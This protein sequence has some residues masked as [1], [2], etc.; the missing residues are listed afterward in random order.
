[1]ASGGLVRLWNE[2]AMQ[3]MVIVSFLLQILLLALGGTRRHSSS[4]VVRLTL[5]LC[6]LMADSTAIYSLGHLSVAAGSGKHQLVAFW[7]P[8]LLLHLG[9][10]DN[11]TAFSLEDN[12]LWL[13]HLQ[14][15]VLQVLGAA[16]VVYKYMVGGG[17]WLLL[18]S[19]SIFV[20]G[21]VK[22]GERIWALRC[23][24]ISNIRIRPNNGQSDP[25]AGRDDAGPL[26]LQNMSDQDILVQAHS[27]FDVCVGIFNNAPQARQHGPTN[28]NAYRQPQVIQYKFAEMVLSLLYDILYTKASVLLTW[29]G[30]CIH[31]IPPL[32][33][34]TALLLFQINIMAPRE[35]AYDR[36]DVIISYVLLVGA[37]VLDIISLCRIVLSCWTFFFLNS[38][39]G[40]GWWWLLQVVSSLRQLVQCETSKRLWKGS[41]GQHD[42]FHLCAHHREGIRGRLAMKMGFQDSWNKMHFSETFLPTGFL[43]VEDLKE[44]VL[45]WLDWY[46]QRHLDYNYRDSYILQTLKNCTE[47]TDPDM[48]QIEM[49]ER[50]LV[51]HIA[52]T[53]YIWKTK[54]EDEDKLVQKMTEAANV[55]SNY[56]M[57]LLVVKPDMLPGFTTHNPYK[58][59][60]NFMDNLWSTN[61][62]MV[63][64]S[65]SWNPCQIIKGW[66]FQHE[67]PNGSS[68]P[69]R[70]KLLQMLVSEYTHQPTKRVEILDEFSERGQET[71][72]KGLKLAEQMEM[73]EDD[74]FATR[75][76]TL[77]LIVSMWVG[78]MWHVGEH[79]SRDSHAKELSNGGEFITILW[80][81]ARYRDHMLFG[82]IPPHPRPP[83]SSDSD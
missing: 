11:I 30:I 43:N 48:S 52:T 80:L 55:L 47:Q 44:I 12:K 14:T 68:I 31:F 79:I 20:A 35:I 38:R 7:A 61:P 25:E 45:G 18:A 70:E 73:V 75:H 50:I 36:V 6:Y 8:F 58:A 1:M 78:L 62:V 37:M 66:L 53:V 2:W 29:H 10:P 4:S 51:W 77:D 41:I 28:G 63:S 15:L 59:A 13:R 3:I 69:E 72:Y 71:V 17:T 24:N 27:H 83:S 34:A 39:P 54:A 19:I 46:S 26:L 16:Y 40:R 32:G 49:E 21:L 65:T 57:F 9:G 33:T 23:G 82:T 42:L 76:D 56:M 64:A 22:Y 5:W 74:E 60:C 81:L 67:G